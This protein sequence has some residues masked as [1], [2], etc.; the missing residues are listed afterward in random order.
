MKSK[1][2]GPDK[3]VKVKGKGRGKIFFSGEIYTP[4]LRIFNI[5]KVI[6]NLIIIVFRLESEE[7]RI[8]EQ[9]NALHKVN[10]YGMQGIIPFPLVIM[11]VGEENWKKMG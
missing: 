2:P 4:G 11:F 6:F 8:K 3:R 9:Y 5:Y 7:Y 1:R 10:I